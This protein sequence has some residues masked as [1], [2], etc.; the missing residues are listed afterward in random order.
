MICESSQ[1]KNH[2]NER[3]NIRTFLSHEGSNNECTSTKDESVS[4]TRRI[5]RSDKL[6]CG[7]FGAFDGLF[8]FTTTGGEFFA[9]DVD[10]DAAVVT[11]VLLKDG[12]WTPK[13]FFFF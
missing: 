11:T 3:I 13:F 5:W 6:L 10:V 9:L 2:P 4:V 12:F 8:D 1:Q 7:S